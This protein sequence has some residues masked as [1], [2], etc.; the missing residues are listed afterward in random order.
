[1]SISDLESPKIEFS[2]HAPERISKLGEDNTINVVGW[3]PGLS[4]KEANES[5][6]FSSPCFLTVDT[7]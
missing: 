3:G 4:E 6:A 1:L 5:A 7:M 2:G